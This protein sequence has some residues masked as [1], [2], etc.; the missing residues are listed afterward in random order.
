MPRGL[1]PKQPRSNQNDHA[2]K[3]TLRLLALAFILTLPTRAADW[4]PAASLA[5]GR[6]RHTA[7]LLPGGKVLVAGG[8]NAL[9]SGYLASAEL[10]D[11]AT[12]AWSA[13][14]SLAT[15]RFR[16]TATLLPSGKVLVAG[17]RDAINTIFASAELF[18]APPISPILYK[19]GDAVPGVAGKTFT[20]FRVPATNEGGTVAFHG[21]WSGG[22]GIFAGGALVVKVG[23]MVGGYALQS[24][25]DPVIDDA[26]HVA[27]PCKLMGAGITALNDAAVVSNAPGGTLAIVAQE[28]TQ[29]A[30]APVGALWKSFT[31]TAAPGGGGGVLILGFMQ[32]GPGGITATTDNGVWSADASGVLHL[33][34]QEGVTVIEGLTVKNFLVLKTV[35]GTPGQTHAFNT[36]AELVA[37]VTF[38]ITNDQALVRLALP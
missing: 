18:D 1:I 34:L 20:S 23:D 3:T 5:T 9:S 6:E 19:E 2:M 12:N 11:P 26:G 29:A 22:A 24:L 31:S 8:Y 38:T 16:H 13:T 7:T 33:V 4:S 30:D 36:N 27:F 28:G 10:Y 35:S 14:G 37:K 21:T 25:S 15:A 32:Q 17:G